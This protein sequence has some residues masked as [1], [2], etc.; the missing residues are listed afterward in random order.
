MKVCVS[1]VCKHRV[2]CCRASATYPPPIPVT[3]WKK[4]MAIWI[5]WNLHSSGK[6][7]SES[8]SLHLFILFSFTVHHLASHPLS[9]AFYCLVS[10][11]LCSHLLPLYFDFVLLCL[12]AVPLSR[13]LTLSLSHFVFLSLISSLWGSFGSEK[14]FG[15]RLQQYF[16]L[17]KKDSWRHSG[18]CREHFLF[19]FSATLPCL[20]LLGWE[21][22]HVLYSAL[23]SSSEAAV[24]GCSRARIIAALG[25]F[26][27]IW[28]WWV[29]HGT[30]KKNMTCNWRWGVS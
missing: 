24:C 23:P 8:L 7:T 6:A 21:R 15:A 12:Y 27:N 16:M 30:K 25:L 20:V 9:S 29:H 17:I 28:Y 19:F 10:P 18:S 4:N 2:F 22:V 13:S 26:S 14:H 5:L 3:S 11:C 1:G